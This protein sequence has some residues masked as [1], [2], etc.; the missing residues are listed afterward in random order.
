MVGQ[1][2]SLTIQGYVLRF[3]AIPR[4]RDLTKP[5]P[6]STS[7]EQPSDSFDGILSEPSS[8]AQAG[9]GITSKLFCLSFSWAASA[10]SAD[11]ITLSIQEI[12]VLID[13]KTEG[14]PSSEQSTPHDRRPWTTAE[15]P[16][17]QTSGLPPSPFQKHTVKKSLTLSTWQASSWPSTSLFP[18]RSGM[19][20]QNCESSPTGNSPNVSLNLL[21]FSQYFSG[22]MF[23]A[24]SRGLRDSLSLARFPQ[25]A[26]QQWRPAF[27]AVSARQAC[28]K[29][30]R[31]AVG[32]ESSRDGTWRRQTSLC[33]PRPTPKS[34][35][36]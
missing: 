17:I 18:F 30:S 23:R 14:C 4:N 5:K 12:W 2:L 3:A 24:T 36:M 15:S 10:S 6:V 7:L 33:M 27:G 9:V 35:G 29:Q 19:P 25:P 22:I 31:H 26:T 1:R 8:N 11:A 28:S 20:A 34:S 21:L 16:S 13:A 32:F